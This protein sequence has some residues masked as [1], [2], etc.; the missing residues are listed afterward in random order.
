MSTAARAR[1]RRVATGWQ[2]AGL[3]ALGAIL[4]LLGARYLFV[5]SGLSLVPWGLVAILVGVLARSRRAA[6][7][8]AAAYGFALSF[9][10]IVAGYDGSATVMSRL[11]F[12][13]VLGL[14]G[15]ACAALLALVGSLVPTATRGRT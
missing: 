3:V 5:G 9:T 10:F 7:G 11:P 12:F 15:A 4:G 6:L 14:V 13:A 8:G 2:Y 1:R